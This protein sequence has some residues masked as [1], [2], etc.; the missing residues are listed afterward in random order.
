MVIVTEFAV[1]MFLAFI[2]LNILKISSLPIF[3]E[4]TLVTWLA[5]AS[6]LIA[7]IAFAI[8]MVFRLGIDSAASLISVAFG[9]GGIILG[10][11]ALSGYK[12]SRL[13]WAGMIFALVPVVYWS[14]IAV[15]FLSG[16][17]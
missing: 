7:M 4:Y 5:F 16:G 6:G 2:I 9:F 8:E 1:G 12:R 17:E 14:A 3:S 10:F 11:G 13:T 15:R